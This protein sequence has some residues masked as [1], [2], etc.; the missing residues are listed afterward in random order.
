MDAEK[1]IYRMI[2]DEELQPNE[3]SG[4]VYQLNIYFQGTIFPK[5]DDMS[6][7]ISEI[8]A[9]DVMVATHFERSRARTAFPCFDEPAMKASFQI[10]LKVPFGYGAI[11]NAA[12]DPDMDTSQNLIVFK[13]TPI[14]STYLVAFVLHKYRHITSESSRGVMFR[15]FYFAEKIDLVKYASV[16]GP[17]ALTYFE[18][19]FG[20]LLYPLEKMDFVPVPDVPFGGE[21]NWGLTIFN[22][23]ALL[24]KEDLMSVKEKCAVLK[25]I[26]HELAHNWVGNL[27]TMRWWNDLWLKE[28]F[29]TYFHFFVSDLIDPDAKYLDRMKID[30]K[31]IMRV[32]GWGVKDIYVLSPDAEVVN[33][34]NEAKYL[35]NSAYNKGACIIQMLD[36]IMTH[37]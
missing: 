31:D 22:P 16:V 36:K 11:S 32:D 30:T 5:P 6:L 9:G 18:N 7:F 12:Y 10:V 13:E 26:V 35:G 37:E 23:S 19:V 29:A 27:V 14:M 25:V 2:L 8:R 34:K 33:T 28:G 21:E 24:Y 17:Q 1:E 15:T 20:N 4:D 3:I